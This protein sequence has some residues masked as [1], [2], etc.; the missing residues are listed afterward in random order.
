MS[1]DQSL[2]MKDFGEFVG[3]LHCLDKQIG[4]SERG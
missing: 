3:N 2:K 1:R 4:F